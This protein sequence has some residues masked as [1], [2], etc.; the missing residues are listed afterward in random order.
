MLYAKRLIIYSIF[1]VALVGLTRGYN[2]QSFGRDLNSYD[3]NKII[4]ENNQSIS[5]DLEAGDM[6]DLNKEKVSLVVVLKYVNKPEDMI[7][8]TV[9]LSNN[10][11]YQT[12]HYEY[13][14]QYHT[15]M[16]NQII[17]GINVGDYEQRY[18]STLTPFVEYTYNVWT[19]DKNKKNILATL[20]QLSIVQTIYVKYYNEDTE[21]VNNMSQGLTMS[22]AYADYTN[23]TY[24]GQGVKVGILEGGVIDTSHSNFTGKSVTIYDQPLYIDNAVEHTTVVASIIGG[25]N[26]IAPDVSFYSTYVHGEL[27]QEVDWLIDQGVHIVNI[28][29]GYYASVGV[30]GAQS[31]YVDYATRVY[32]R[33]FVITAGNDGEETNHYVSNPGLAYNAL[34]VGAIASSGERSDLSSYGATNGPIKPNIMAKGE[35]VLVP[36]FDG[37]CFSGTSVSAPMVTGQIALLMER[38]PELKNKPMKVI[39][40]VTANALRRDLEGYYYDLNNNFNEMMGAGEFNYTNI[41]NNYVNSLE[42]VH[43]TTA[44]SSIVYSREFTL[45]A[46]ETLQAAITWFSCNDE[47]DTAS[48]RTDYD[49]RLLSN[50]IVYSIGCTTYNNV[51]MVNFTATY[52]NTD[53]SIIIIQHTTQVLGIETINFSYNIT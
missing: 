44:D 50:N 8:E 15:T 11:E 10:Y 23:H 9:L 7:P 19:F 28:S 40:L 34:T 20:Q 17:N 6:V 26:G 14:K 38:Y 5:R 12:E 42:I 37:E 1:I 31:A 22:G 18:I 24:T 33:L 48:Q 4:F 3:N 46:G 41:C 32:R 52:N 27:I 47:D 29:Y 36:G 21:I 2:Y 16:N 30:Y 13:Y 35:G 45:N 51:E 43:S 25:V 53:C 39:S 49:I